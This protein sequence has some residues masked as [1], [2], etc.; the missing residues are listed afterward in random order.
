MRAVRFLLLVLVLALAACGPTTRPSDLATQQSLPLA[1]SQGGVAPAATV[2]G[3]QVFLP[4][5][6]QQAVNTPNPTPAPSATPPPPVP[7]R[8]AVIGDYGSGGGPAADVANL[9]L[10]WAPDFIITTGDNNY[11]DGS[12]TTIDANVGQ[13]YHS[14]IFPYT[15]NYGPGADRNRF[16]P[17]LGNHDWSTNSAQPYLDYFTLPGNERYY[18][19]TWGPLDFFVLDS[20]SREPDEVGSGSA[21]A[22]WL[23]QKLAESPAIWKIV[24]LHH[25][26]YSSG[27]HGGTDWAIWPYQEWGADA[28]L[29]GHD[30]TY[31]RLTIDGIP[32]F[33]NGLGG[34]AIYSFFNV[35]DGSQIRYNDDYGA[36]L[37]E[38][39][40]QSIT[41]QFV[42]RQG[43]VIDTFTE[44]K[45]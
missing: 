25:A 2:A 1:A 45:P 15:G 34:G 32:Y 8:F 40:E 30:H 11:P 4:L 23:Q 16:F 3:T 44:Q 43:E 7:L 12:D 35:V 42:S 41:F 37:V 17:S 38:A 14:Y 29:A 20:D 36:M 39:D 22:D 19:F 28:V 6:A 13:F 21:Q 24:Y 10:S 18:D 27:M 9:V 33:V 31:E 26:P 5:I